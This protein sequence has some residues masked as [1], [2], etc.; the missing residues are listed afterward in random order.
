M[1]GLMRGLLWF[2]VLALVL[3]SCNSSSSLLP[4]SG[5]SDEMAKTTTAGVAALAHPGQDP[6]QDAPP[7]SEVAPGVFVKA[8]TPENSDQRFEVV[9]FTVDIRVHGS[10]AQLVP[11]FMNLDEWM[12][13]K[14]IHLSPMEKYYKFQRIIPAG[15]Q[16][17]E[18][19]PFNRA[20][21]DPQQGGKL[22]SPLT[23]RN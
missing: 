7:G 13:L 22:G 17:P 2:P 23:P 21:T 8:F 16:A 4:G 12:I 15:T 11:Y 9:E 20:L 1:T 5:M 19:D 10:Q 6:T 14:V 18:I 3:A